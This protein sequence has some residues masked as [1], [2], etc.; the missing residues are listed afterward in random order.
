MLCDAKRTELWG[1]LLVM[2]EWLYFLLPPRDDFA[3]TMTPEEDEAFVDHFS[4]MEKLLAE[5]VLVLAGPTLG[6]ANT[7]V[8]IFEAEDGEAAR[9]IME[10]DPPV[11]RGLVRGQLRPFKVMQL[12]GRE[13][14]VPSDP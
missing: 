12:R 3:A 8:C 13:S 9:K 7:G 10:A 6:P 11:A 5:G 2:A 14:D 4:Y 1:I